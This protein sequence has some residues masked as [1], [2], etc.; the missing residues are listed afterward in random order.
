MYIERIARSARSAAT[1][2]SQRARQV[3]DGSLTVHDAISEIQSLPL[4]E[5][6]SAA[7]AMLSLHDVASFRAA[8][9]ALRW[10]LDPRAVIERSFAVGGASLTRELAQASMLPSYELC[11]LLFA[12]GGHALAATRAEAARAMLATPLEGIDAWTW[13]LQL[14]LALDADEVRARVLSIAEEIDAQARA[15]AFIEPTEGELDPRFAVASA[16]VHLGEIGQACAWLDRGLRE[17]NARGR[18]GWSTAIRSV[19]RALTPEQ[20]RALGQRIIEELAAQGAIVTAQTWRAAAA[21]LD[22]MS[23]QTCLARAEA[24]HP[25]PAQNRVPAVDLAPW[26]RALDEAQRARRWPAI[27]QLAAHAVIEPATLFALC[28]PD[29]LESWTRAHRDAIRSIEGAANVL[30]A[31]APGVA[32]ASLARWV[33]DQ[34]SLVESTLPA[35]AY[36]VATAL[37]DDER[38]LHWLAERAGDPAAIALDALPPR[39]LAARLD[40]MLGANDRALEGAAWS[41]LL[42][43]LATRPEHR[44]IG[45]RCAAWVLDERAFLQ[46]DSDP[47]A[48]ATVRALAAALSL[49]DAVRLWQRALDSGRGALAHT[50]LARVSEQSDADPERA[51]AC[52]EATI[53]RFTMVARDAWP[54][55]C[56]RSLAEG[57][58]FCWPVVPAPDVLAQSYERDVRCFRVGDGALPWGASFDA[59][60]AIDWAALLWPRCSP[61]AREH[62]RAWLEP[63]YRARRAVGL[64]VERW[65]AEAVSV[66]CITDAWT[67]WAL[68]EEPRALLRCAHELR[69]MGGEE[70][71]DAITDALTSALLDAALAGPREAERAFG[72]A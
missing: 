29:A 54:R 23:A 4:D 1:S 58:A 41:P 47:L 57:A 36:A 33:T 38:A 67:R 25:A 24:H 11:S 7:E 19:R 20:D 66:S 49:E 8:I 46:S 61:Q 45:A 34:R 56:W 72:A 9:D 28:P 31:M 55:V 35:H 32:R 71:I 21:A 59:Q 51:V 40:A 26:L 2:P 27:A 50:L 65:L 14:A 6:R 39:I 52:A 53:T 43:H 12:L 13:A 37:E 63:A 22:P 44:A 5:Q 16:M 15:G 10:Q 62:A 42:A 18:L 3:D 48:P 69:A 64:S 60:R 17:D 70:A 68:C 30:R